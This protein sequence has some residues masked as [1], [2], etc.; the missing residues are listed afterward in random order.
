MC[1]L[2]S[3][4]SVLRLSDG[5]RKVNNRSNPKIIKKYSIQVKNEVVSFLDLG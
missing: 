4:E 3:I 1:N 2:T 5:E